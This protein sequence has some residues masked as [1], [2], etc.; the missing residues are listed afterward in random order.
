[1]EF[2]LD[3]DNFLVLLGPYIQHIFP[4]KCREELLVLDSFSADLSDTV[5]V[6]EIKSLISLIIPETE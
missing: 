1:M 6:N 5:N 4:C 2:L 3:F